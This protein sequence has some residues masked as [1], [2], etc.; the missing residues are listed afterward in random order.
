MEKEFNIAQFYL[1][2]AKTSTSPMEINT[3]GSNSQGSRF[4]GRNNSRQ[5]EAITAPKF[6]NTPSPMWCFM[7]TAFCRQG[8][9]K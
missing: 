4:G 9:T 3:A 8:T 6:R 7:L 5:M 1:P 2:V